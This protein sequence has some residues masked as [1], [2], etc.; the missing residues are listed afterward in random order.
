MSVYDIAGNELT[1][2][3]DLTG[4]QMDVAYDIEGN[5]ILKPLQTDLIIMTYNV[6]RFRERNARQDMQEEI[7]NKYLPDVIGLQEIGSKT[8]PSL[9]A[10]I[11]A[12]YPYQFIGNESNNTGIVSKSELSNPTFTAYTSKASETRGYEKAYITV[13]GKQIA[14]F[15]TH[16][17]LISS[18]EPH[19]A[20]AKELFDALQEEERFV[21][22]GDFN[23]ECHDTSDS[24][25]TSVV[26]QFIDA[27]YNMVNWKKAFV[28][29]W[30]NGQTFES[31][32]Y[33]YPC[34]NIITSANIN[35]NDVVFDSTKNDYVT[36]N[37]I[38]HI[39]VIAY[40]SVN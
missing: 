34:D 12:D 19:S 1:S 17:E 24:E 31:S 27:G 8:M 26:K 16:L 23:V 30:F 28:D 14:I 29:T 32:I 37:G 20:Q 11:F 6:Q 38:D 35:I 33:K 2:V 3:N 22:L 4:L 18:G 40:L 21:A 9:G 39:P 7:I 25:Y 13:N 5:K 10:E 36:S 15:N